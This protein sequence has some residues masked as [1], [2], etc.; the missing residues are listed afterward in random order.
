MPDPV[1]LTHPT[2]GF[3]V[4]SPMK[5]YMQP[6]ANELQQMI[7]SGQYLLSEKIDGAW[8]QL[9]ISPE[10]D[11]HLFS[12]TIS[13]KDG[14]F[15]DKIDNVPHLMKWAKCLPND[16]TIIGEIFV[17]GGKSN[18]VT[19]IMGCIPATAQQR[20][21]NMTA[22]GGPIHYY[23]HDCIR[24]DGEDLMEQPLFIR[25]QYVNQ[26]TKLFNYNQ[27]IH[28][29]EYFTNNDDLDYIHA[30]FNE[31]I[32]EIFAAGKEG[33]VLK[34]INGMY[35][36][37]KRPQTNKKVKEHK[38]NIDLVIM[39]CLDPERV[40]TGTALDTWQYWDG[41]TPVTKPY[42][43]GWKNA[44]K[45]GAYDDNGNLIP[46]GRVASGFTDE[47]REAMGNDPVAFLGQVIECACMSVDKNELTL[48][49]PV[50]VRFR[51]DKNITDCKISEIFN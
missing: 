34:D 5:I 16:T 11:P 27:Y 4:Y 28:F 21:Y 26:V 13:K 1:F 32:N 44:V 22:Y 39:E 19:S 41:D 50:F 24:F 23:I 8:F 46:I 3:K 43:F 12:R 20:Q 9:M 40:Y 31:C 17:P 25:L 36:P 2:E 51:P 6:S 15:V 33:V 38:D 48:R 10:G 35:E 49:H 7:S 14:F 37:G 45:V 30:D 42:Y 47:D 18:N 29:A